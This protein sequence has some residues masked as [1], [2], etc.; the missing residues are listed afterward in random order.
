MREEHFFRDP[1]VLNSQFKEI[2]DSKSTRGDLYWSRI[3]KFY[4]IER[5]NWDKFLEINEVKIKHRQVRNISSANPAARSYNKP[6]IYNFKDRPVSSYFNAQSRSFR[7][8]LNLI[9][10]HNKEILIAKEVLIYK[11]LIV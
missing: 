7:K 3:N 6:V 9:K 4:V 1:V 8:E 10:I 11:I 2:L 5:E